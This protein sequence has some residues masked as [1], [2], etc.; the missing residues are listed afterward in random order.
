MTAHHPTPPKP[1]GDET[2]AKTP[3]D[4]VGRPVACGDIVSVTDG[5]EPVQAV[6]QRVEGS[7]LVLQRNDGRRAAV[8]SGGVVVVQRVE[9]AGGA[10]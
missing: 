8:D 4:A 3:L 1:K 10:A 7:W 9:R 2:R 5:A 6:V